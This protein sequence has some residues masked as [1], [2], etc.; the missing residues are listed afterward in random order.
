[1]KVFTF[2]SPI[3]R[4]IADPLFRNTHG[5]ERH[6]FVVPVRLMPIDIPDEP[7]ARRPNTN[8]RVYQQVEKSLL[9]KE[10]EPGLFHLKNKGITIIAKRV[11]PRGP[12]KFDVHLE[13]G[14][15]IVDG[16]HTYKLII[17]NLP[18]EE[19]PEDQYVNVEVRVGIPHEWI[20]DLAQ[21]LNTSV[22][23]QDMSLDNLK[24]MFG[25]LRKELST[26]PY[27]KQIA[28]SENDE[29]EYDA[30]DVISLLYAFNTD[31]FPNKPSAD[32]PV[33]A[34]EKKAT[35]LKAFEQ[36]DAFKRMQPI[37]KDIL[38]LH[39]IIAKEG[40]EIWNDTIPSGKAGKLAWVEHRENK[41]RPYTF[42][43]TGQKSENRLFDGALYPM[44]AAYRWYVDTDPK[45]LKYRWRVPFDQVVK[46]FRERDGK[47]LLIATR[48]KSD[49][50]GRNPNAIGKSRPHWA[51]L[52]TIV[53]KNDLMAQQEDAR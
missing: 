29:G 47:E 38:R 35:A 13:P 11:E 28:W 39:D 51:S 37:L 14:H 33:A 5:T 40:P 52:Y 34:Y 25:W 6:L 44:L 21:G 42:Y 9:N 1:M 16:G 12:D 30:R 46:A 53:V 8:R 3:S 17:D 15:G 31:L 10:G 20:P 2:T 24:G 41:R 27:H 18:N 32:H 23:V 36:N 22:Q 26:E 4:R 48:G 50:L 7:N 43:F 49:E 19:L 45:T